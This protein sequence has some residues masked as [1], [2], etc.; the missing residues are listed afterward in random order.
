MNLLYYIVVV[1]ECVFF[2]W[3]PRAHTERPFWMATTTPQDGCKMAGPWL[4]KKIGD[5]FS[6]PQIFG[7][8]Q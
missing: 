6:G 2:T 3:H 1:R 8:P 7:K 5:I 4:Q